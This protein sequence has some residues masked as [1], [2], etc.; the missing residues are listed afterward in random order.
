MRSLYCCMFLLLFSLGGP[1]LLI[2]AQ[3]RPLNTFQQQVLKREPEL[4]QAVIL[5]D[6]A[7]TRSLL[8]RGADANM[9][10]SSGESILLL[11]CGLNGKLE[12]VKSLLDHGAKVN[13]T[14][15][16]PQ[17]PLVR[18]SAWNNEEI[19]ALLIARKANVNQADIGRYSAL[20]TA[21]RH[22]EI[23]IVKLLLQH[24]ANVNSQSNDGMTALET[25][26]G[27]GFSDEVKLLLAH[28]ADVNQKGSRGRTP[29][30][31]ALA[32]QKSGEDRSD[33]IA[34]LKQAGAKEK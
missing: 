23:G 3:S 31:A 22:H 11:A 5:R 1:K 24:G 32:V 4:V 10:A 28:G 9:K 18:A 34:L 19:A 30:A 6:P 14:N 12:I 20:T 8:A 26:A 21:V 17:P 25:A 13:G 15:T 16:D 27:R 2:F 33:V 7:K 29:L